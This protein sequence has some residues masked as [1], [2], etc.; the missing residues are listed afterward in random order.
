MLAGNVT[1]GL[2][3]AFVHSSDTN[4][5]TRL[6]SAQLPALR[7]RRLCE[8]GFRTK[9]PVAVHGQAPT[10][11]HMPQILRGFCSH[12]SPKALLGCH[13]TIQ[14]QPQLQGRGR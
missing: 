8:V 2:G 14:P 13:L 5:Y 11:A 6:C 7:Q 1:K 4:M 3:D 9:L 10:P 12:R